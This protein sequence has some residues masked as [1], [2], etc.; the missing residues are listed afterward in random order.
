MTWDFRLRAQ[1]SIDVGDIPLVWISFHLW[2]MVLGD[3]W[4]QE[5]SFPGFRLLPANFPKKESSN[6][7]VAKWMQYR[8]KKKK[9]QCQ[10]R[11]RILEGKGKGP[12]PC[13]PPSLS[14]A[15]PSADRGWT[16]LLLV[17]SLAQPPSP[18]EL[19][20]YRA[21]LGSFKTS[22]LRVV[23]LCRHCHPQQAPG[24]LC[25]Q[26]PVC[27]GPRDKGP[28]CICIPPSGGLGS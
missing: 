17:C 7:I 12:V 26:P 23:W 8:K 13:P 9:S 5:T 21:L 28:W 27:S 2:W 6:K 10:T 19:S 25:A 11:H 20:V 16:W 22:A 4:L 15:V 24:R 18:R 14:W 1:M 3:L